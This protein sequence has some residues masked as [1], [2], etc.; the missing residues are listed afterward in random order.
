M[1]GVTFGTIILLKNTIGC[2][3]IL[4]VL[5]SNKTDYSASGGVSEKQIEM[6]FTGIDRKHSRAFIQHYLGL[7]GRHFQFPTRALQVRVICKYFT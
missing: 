7:S 5:L 3:S 6:R 1:V 2:V 4:F